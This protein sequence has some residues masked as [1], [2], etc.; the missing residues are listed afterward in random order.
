MYREKELKILKEL[1]KLDN[2]FV[3]IY[4]RRRIGKTRL[5]EEFLKDKKGV[6]YTPEDVNKKIQIMEFKE[7]L[8]DFLNDN[9]LKRIELDSWSELFSYLE[10]KSFITFLP[11][12]R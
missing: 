9:F 11:T 5:I 8:A 6:S 3:V 10:R 2:A 7:C 1:W 12:L 4:G